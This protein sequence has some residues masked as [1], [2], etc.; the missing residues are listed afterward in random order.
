[1]LNLTLS[2]SDEAAMP[3]GT[4]LQEPAPMNISIMGTA[5]FAAAA[6]AD[7]SSSAELVEVV[8]TVAAQRDE[9]PL[10]LHRP[11]S[12]LQREVHKY[13]ASLSK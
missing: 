8:G 2:L 9:L 1:M 11:P 10:P 7:C 13:L 12:Q 6:A 5:S 4:R 3:Q